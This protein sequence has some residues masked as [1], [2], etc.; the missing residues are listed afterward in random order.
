MK[1]EKI[2]GAAS[3]NNRNVSSEDEEERRKSDVA[4]LDKKN[5]EGHVYNKATNSTPEER[6]KS[7]GKKTFATVLEEELSRGGNVNK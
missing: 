3:L 2:A 5:T 7:V 4:D 1:V 6:R